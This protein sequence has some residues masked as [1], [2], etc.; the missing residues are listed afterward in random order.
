MQKICDRVRSQ[1]VFLNKVR[2]FQIIYVGISWH[3]KGVHFTAKLGNGRKQFQFQIGKR[4][5]FLRIV[6]VQYLV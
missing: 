1:V 5:G 6:T 2:E 3:A 4:K